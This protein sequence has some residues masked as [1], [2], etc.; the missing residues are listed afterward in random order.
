MQNQEAE[1]NPRCQ[2]GARLLHKLSYRNAFLVAQPCSAPK[3]S[4]IAPEPRVSSRGKS[5][6]GARGMQN[7]EAEENPRCQKGAHLLHKLSYRNAFLVAQPCPAPK[8]S[9]IA[10]EPRVPFR[11]KSYRVNR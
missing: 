3:R 8:R 5:Y 2:K 11:G 10:P 1:E 7:Q 9:R 4:K 6:R